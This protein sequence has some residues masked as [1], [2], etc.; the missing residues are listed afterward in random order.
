MWV[1]S[2]THSLTHSYYTIDK[3]FA[4][5]IF[6]YFLRIHICTKA[7]ERSNYVLFISPQ[8]I[9]ESCLKLLHI[10][11]WC[12]TYQTLQTIKRAN[13][14]C[15]CCLFAYWKLYLCYLI[16]FFLYELTFKKPIT[17]LFFV[18]NSKYF[19]CC[20]LQVLSLPGGEE[21]ALTLTYRSET[22]VIALIE[23]QCPTTHFIVSLDKI[24]YLW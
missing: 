8:N 17:L 6:S 5:G 7:L 12:N 18:C 20:C 23:L 4:L 3:T 11:T 2:I 24:F 22:S 10:K 1:L 14:E 19:Q 9:T 15:M 21:S 13:K 16:F